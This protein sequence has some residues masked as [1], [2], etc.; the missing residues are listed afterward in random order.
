MSQNESLK[1]DEWTEKELL[2]HIYRELVDVKENLKISDQTHSDMGIRL[3]KLETQSNLLKIVVT[4]FIG[5][6]S[7][8]VAVISLT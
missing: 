7:L 8:F 5:L 6:G 1:L 4:F 3:T 2:R